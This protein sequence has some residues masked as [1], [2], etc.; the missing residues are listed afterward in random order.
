MSD[1]VVNG[2]TYTFPDTYS[3]EQARDILVRHGVIKL[4][5]GGGAPPGPSTPPSPIKY[6]GPH[7]RPQDQPPLGFQPNEGYTPISKLGQNILPLVAVGA[8][9]A[10]ELGSAVGDLGAAARQGA[11]TARNTPVAKFDPW[12]ALGVEGLT[13]MLGLPKGVGAAVKTGISAAPK[14]GAFVR[15]ATQY[16]GQKPFGPE[17]QIAPVGETAPSTSPVANSA[18]P[19]NDWRFEDAR[20]MARLL[21]QHG[22][23]PADMEDEQ[24][25]IAAPALKRNLGVPN[26]HAK[27][28][29]TQEYNKLQGA[30]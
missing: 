26:A 5:G 30:Q 10:P 29:V 7:D 1:Y 20:D 8:A 9:A 4:Q 24:W 22:I 13:E 12:A 15:G 21:N 3:D 14:A 23:N 6:I 2:Q 18:Q 17:L 27:E 11:L 19:S 25:E 16:L 28:W